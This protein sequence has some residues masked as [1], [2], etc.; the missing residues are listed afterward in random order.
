MHWL[1]ICHASV[2]LAAST[3]VMLVKAEFIKSGRKWKGISL[4]NNTVYFQVAYVISTETFIYDK[5][6]SGSF[7]FLTGRKIHFSGKQCS[8][9][10]NGP[11]KILT[12]CPN[13]AWSDRIPAV[14]TNW[15]MML[16]NISHSEHRADQSWCQLCNSC[17]RTKTWK[18]FF[19]YSNL[20]NDC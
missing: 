15:S 19:N 20:E 6:I 1:L 9:K 12:L 3:A 5:P 4:S 13:Q 2:L 16:H 11:Q 8:F 17:C 7:I 10:W 14:N 18:F